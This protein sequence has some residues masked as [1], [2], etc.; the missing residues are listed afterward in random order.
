MIGE[1]RKTATV[2]RIGR[3][4]TAASAADAIRDAIIEGT[5]AIGQPLSE[6]SLCSSLGI[7]RTPL[8]E[9]LMELEG[10]GLVDIA[11]YKGASVFFLSPPQIRQ[12]GRFRKLLELAALEAAMQDR[13]DELARDLDEVVA[14]MGAIFSTDSTSAYGALDTRLHESLIAHG[15]NAYIRQAY[16]IVGLKL[17]VFRNLIPRNWD[18]I[19]NAQRDHLALLEQVK[20]GRVD[21][22]RAILERHIDG[23]TENYAANVNEALQSKGPGRTGE[24]DD[25]GS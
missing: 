15:G 25:A 22:A 5:L 18:Y 2:R 6:A 13:P 19:T 1:E 7:S 9:A 10:Q 12:L 20:A 8:R 21:R 16:Q 11:P 4:S 23:G 17:A 3:R 24:P 14:E